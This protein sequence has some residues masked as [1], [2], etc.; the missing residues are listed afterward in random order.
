MDAYVTS[1]VP[2]VLQEVAAWGGAVTTLGSWTCGTDNPG[3]LSGG[4]CWSNVPE[5][6]MSITFNGTGIE[7]YAR[8][9]GENGM[10][11]V[12]LNGAFSLPMTVLACRTTAP[13]S[14]ASMLK[15]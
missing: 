4:H 9:D 12:Y 8:P 11:H 13:A 10:T 3:D 14:I 2:L 6:G 1:G 5:D 7:V 15:T